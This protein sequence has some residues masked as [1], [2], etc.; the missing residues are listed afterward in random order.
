MPAGPLSGVDRTK[1]EGTSDGNDPK[2]TFDL[3]YRLM[4]EGRYGALTLVVEAHQPF[5]YL[6]SWGEV[7]LPP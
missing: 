2:P 5:Y 4:A 1:G 3:V 6:A 7:Y